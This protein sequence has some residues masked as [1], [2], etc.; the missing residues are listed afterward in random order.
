[1]SRLRIGKSTLA[2]R[3]VAEH[4]GVLIGDIDET[5]DTYDALV[6]SLV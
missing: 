5:Y 4:P 6:T 1:M 3:Y 2:P